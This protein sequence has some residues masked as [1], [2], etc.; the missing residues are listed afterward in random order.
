MFSSADGKTLHIEVLGTLMADNE[1]R[2]DKGDLQGL[3]YDDELF[4]ST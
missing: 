2:G 1:R 3:A 4:L